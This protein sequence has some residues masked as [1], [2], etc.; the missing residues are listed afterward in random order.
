MTLTTWQHHNITYVMPYDNAVRKHPDELLQKFA[1][2]TTEIEFQYPK[3]V[4]SVKW[5]TKL[6]VEGYEPILVQVENVID[7]HPF[8][9]YLRE[10]NFHGPREPSTT[11]CEYNCKP[12]KSRETVVT[13]AGLSYKRFRFLYPADCSTEDILNIG[14]RNEQK[15]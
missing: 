13:A 5:W 3:T 8:Q 1:G 2:F 11:V 9:L 10:V 15:S 7:D 6:Y 14:Q 4:C 12:V